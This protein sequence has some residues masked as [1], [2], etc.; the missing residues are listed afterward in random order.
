[1]VL[2]PSTPL[3]VLNVA[4]DHAAQV[5]MIGRVILDHDSVAPGNVR[6]LNDFK[7]GRVILATAPPLLRP[8]D[9]HVRSGT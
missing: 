5:R 2:I 8:P 4:V 6:A 1:M 9:G 7:A 3:D